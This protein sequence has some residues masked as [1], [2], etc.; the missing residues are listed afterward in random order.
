MECLGNIC[1]FIY[2]YIYIY[3]YSYYIYIYII[4]SIIYIYIYIVKGNKALVHESMDIDLP[5]WLKRPLKGK[6]PCVSCNALLGF[7]YTQHSRCHQ[8]KQ[9][10]GQGSIC[11]QV[12]SRRAHFSRRE[13]ST[14]VLVAGLSEQLIVDAKDQSAHHRKDARRQRR[15]AHHAVYLQ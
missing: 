12:I 6:Q 8:S 14:C 10:P 7:G 4:S 13:S 9:H 2:I 15:F 5:L 1:I 3:N 11:S